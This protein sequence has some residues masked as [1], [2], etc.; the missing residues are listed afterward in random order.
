MGAATPVCGQVGDMVEQVVRRHR[1]GCHLLLLTSVPRSPVFLDII[2][3]L[4]AKVK[5]VM[6]VSPDLRHPRKVLAGDSTTSCRIVVLY[7]SSESDTAGGVAADHGHPNTTD[8]AL[9]LL[10][11]EGLYKLPTTRVVVVGGSDGAQDVLLHHSLRNT[12]HGTYLGLH[13]AHAT[14]VPASTHH[15]VL[16]Y[17]TRQIPIYI[18]SEHQRNTIL[19]YLSLEQLNN[20]NGH[21]LKIISVTYFPYVDY[22]KYSDALG[23]TVELI[24]SLDYRLLEAFAGEHNFT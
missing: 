14:P 17:V 23:G 8:Q 2:R 19:C 20:F 21:Q 18:P 13:A 9:R 12:I 1:A 15:R 4:D 7:L 3:H 6:A 16:R 24:D 11:R 22:R 5:A 10:E